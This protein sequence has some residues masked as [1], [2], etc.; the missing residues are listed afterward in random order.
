MEHVITDPARGRGKGGGI[1]LGAHAI[2]K[3]G[4]ACRRKK[5]DSS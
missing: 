5:P 3:E 2:K 4:P 1:E